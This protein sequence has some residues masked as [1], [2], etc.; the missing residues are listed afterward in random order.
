MQEDAPAQNKELYLNQGLLLEL[1]V[2]RLSAK[3]PPESLV[4]AYNFELMKLSKLC[5]TFQRWKGSSVRSWGLTL[6]RVSE[7]A[8]GFFK[9]LGFN[10][11][12]R[13]RDGCGL[14]KGLGV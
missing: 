2:I 1:R 5:G 12:G 3:P 8:A 10:L 6:L 9:V 7:M 4:E 14:L 13:F 11:V